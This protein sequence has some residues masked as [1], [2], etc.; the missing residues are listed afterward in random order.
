M[1]SRNQAMTEHVFHQEGAVDPGSGR[2]IV[3]RRAGPTKTWPL[4]VPNTFFS[5]PVVDDA[6][7]SGAITEVTARLYHPE[8]D[9]PHH[10]VSKAPNPVMEFTPGQI[11]DDMPD[12]SQGSLGT[13]NE[14]TQRVLSR[15]LDEKIT[16]IQKALGLT[17]L[18]M[19]EI[20]SHWMTRTARRLRDAEVGET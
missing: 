14:F 7:I 10:Y 2:C 19:M 6:G 11:T 3:W 18:Q 15:Q 1:I 4:P 8:M 20:V 13:R 16:E 5:V 9:C 17:D 12:T